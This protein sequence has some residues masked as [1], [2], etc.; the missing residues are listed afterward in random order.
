MRAFL[1]ASI[2]PVVVIGAAPALAQQQQGPFPPGNG[3]DIVA[4]ACMQCHGPGVIVNQRQGANAWRYYVQNM[5]LR[6]AQ[7]LPE[8]LDTVVNYLTVN[9]GPGVNVPQSTPVALPKGDGS[10]IV[11]GGCGGLCHGLDR[12]ALA[13]RK[14]AEWSAIVKRMVFLGAPIGD[15]DITKVTAYLSDKFGAP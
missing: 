12:I 13:K 11:E 9:F 8:E 5:F 2:L 10:E 14:P 1:I 3:R 15:Q 7:V 6:G 4:V